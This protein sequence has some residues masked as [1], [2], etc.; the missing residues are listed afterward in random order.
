MHDLYHLKSDG[1]MTI[2]LPHGVLFRG[3]EEGEIR[4]NLIE[5]NNIDCIIG[6][7]ANIFYGTGIPTIIMILRKQR[8][9]T[10]TQIIDA[11]KGFTKEG[12]NNKLRACDI[13]KIVDA[14]IERKNIDK[15][16]KVVS[17]EEI[18][19]NDYNLN[20][21]RYVDS[22]EQQE[23][24]DIYASMFGG[25]PEE[26]LKKYDKI[27]SAFP[28]LK[29]KLLKKENEKH[30]KI[31]SNNIKETIEDDEDV[32]NFKES[33][34]KSFEDFDGYLKNE[35]INNK[36]NVN[37][38]S[39]EK[40]LS[41]FM[42]NKLNQYNL[43]DNYKAYQTLD[44]SWNIISSD[45]ETIQTEG[46]E[47]ARKYEEEQ[48]IISLDLIQ[49]YKLKDK[50]E[51]LENIKNNQQ[52]MATKAEEILDEISEDAKQ[53]IYTD[54]KVDYKRVAE[55][56]KEYKNATN[57]DSDEEK[58]VKLNKLKEQEKKINK[59]I[60]DTEIKLKK[61]SIK[62]IEN[63]TES[64][65]DNLLYIKWI[66]SLIDNLNKLPDEVLSEFTKSIENATKKYDTTLVDLDKEINETEKEL[67]NM[68]DN[69]TGDEFDMKGLEEFKTLLG[70]E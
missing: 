2:V 15:F 11:S 44:D 8:E 25:I 1:I 48:P 64:E 10:D 31:I 24:Y 56:V 59:E 27:W 53:E 54:E 19:K 29:D 22:S 39:K 51:E 42:F 68:I 34:R 38:N 41:D 49:N 20:I 47:A 37:I 14:V 16:S 63:L 5:N 32:K 45:L 17:R 43:I 21:P 50:L 61:E 26:E 62:C 3:G 4:K 18:R 46:I 67:S 66:K 58:I 6:L 33:F 13:K 36:M 40:E 35:L 55:K 7:P 23:H 12:K 69:L 60:K 57:L 65:I 52:D 70:G 9:R 30:Y 28:K